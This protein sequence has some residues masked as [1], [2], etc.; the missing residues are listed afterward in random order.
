MLARSR[1]P[2]GPGPDVLACDHRRFAVG[3]AVRC[4]TSLCESPLNESP[5]NDPA[6]NDPAMC[7][8][9]RKEVLHPWR[10]DPAFSSSRAEPASSSS[11]APSVRRLP[12]LV[13]VEDC[14][15]AMSYPRWT[16]R[17]AL[18]EVRIAS[19]VSS[20]CRSAEPNHQGFLSLGACRR[21]LVAWAWNRES[22]L[23][24]FD[25]AEYWQ[26][27]LAGLD[28][29]LT[30]RSAE[31]AA[32]FCR[33]PSSRFPACPNRVSPR[34]AR[35]ATDPSV[36]RCFAG[37]MVQELHPASKNRGSNCD[38][39]AEFVAVRSCCCRLMSHRH[40]AESLPG[41]A[42]CFRT[43]RD[44]AFGDSAWPAA[45]VALPRD[46]P[47]ANQ[48]ESCHSSGK[49]PTAFADAAVIPFATAHRSVSAS[50]FRATDVTACS[51][52]L[53]PLPASPERRETT[54]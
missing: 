31:A 37:P 4:L 19:M 5:L 28:L 51:L 25:L 13:L 29:F 39:L 48:L 33:C 41:L 46:Q 23:Q 40:Q 43:A 52:E 1:C 12:A 9:G 6:L 2:R 34:S 47:V 18:A 7:L 3:L 30:G 21:C 50:R 32:R 45:D 15:E 8:P 36:R 44:S 22:C 53:S 11:A 42:K 20:S 38:R 49:P 10:I 54:A 26:I 27:C 14:F 35:P 16:G 17:R 24:E